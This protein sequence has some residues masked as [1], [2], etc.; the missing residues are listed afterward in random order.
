MELSLLQPTIRSGFAITPVCPSLISRLVNSTLG[1]QDKVLYSFWLQY[2][3]DSGEWRKK[4]QRLPAPVYQKDA[5]D[6]YFEDLMADSENE[7]APFMYSGD[8]LYLRLGYSDLSEVHILV[9][10][11]DLLF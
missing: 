1:L 3:F 6:L 7:V 4:T 9:N 2:H 10:S 11:F 8:E 5:R